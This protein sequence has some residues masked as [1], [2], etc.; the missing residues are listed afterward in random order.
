N[1]EAAAHGGMAMRWLQQGNI[2][3]AAAA[4]QQGHAFTPD[5]K[6]LGIKTDPKTGQMSGQ[7]FDEFT[8]QPLTPP[9]AI[10]PQLLLAAA[11]GLRDGSG[12]W[13]HLAMRG[14]QA[15]A[16]QKVGAVDKDAE[17]RALRNRRTVEQIALLEARRRKIAGGGGG[18]AGA[19]TG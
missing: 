19:G 14:R 18:G 1:L 6:Q 5:G 16:R 8:G 12:M 17:G 7:M 15:A 13:N 4:A 11:V 9:F 10:T 2:P 3:M